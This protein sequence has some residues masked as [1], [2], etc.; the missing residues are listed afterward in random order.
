LTW[1]GMPLTMLSEDLSLFISPDCIWE[2]ENYGR[3]ESQGSSKGL[4]AR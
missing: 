3:F 2:A 1:L 4:H